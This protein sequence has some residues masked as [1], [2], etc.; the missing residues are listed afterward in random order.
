MGRHATVRL[1]DE[2]GNPGCGW[3]LLQILYYHHWRGVRRILPRRKRGK[4]KSSTWTGTPEHPQQTGNGQEFSDA[5][6]KSILI[7][8]SNPKTESG[9]KWSIK[10]RIKAL[11]AAEVSK[12]DDAK[13]RDQ[14]FPKQS[15]QKSLHANPSLH[16]L[17]KQSAGCR[18][19]N[20]LLK[21]G[22]E[23]T[24][25]S[26][27]EHHLV[28]DHET[29]VASDEEPSFEKSAISQED[30]ANQML[31]K[32][33]QLKRCLTQKDFKENLDVLEFLRVKKELSVK[34][35][36]D[37]HAAFASQLPS[38]NEA[39]QTARLIKSGS[40]PS[41][42]S[43]RIRLGTPSTLEQK[44]KE[45]WPSK[46]GKFLLTPEDDGGSHLKA[47]DISTSNDSKSG[48]LYRVRRSSSL[49]E[50][51]DKHTRLFN[52]DFNKE[53]TR[54]ISR[55][56]KLR[57]EKDFTLVEYTPNVFRR[58]LSLPEL[59]SYSFLPIDGSRDA[60]FSE[61][62]INH[63]EDSPKRMNGASDDEAASLPFHVK[64]EEP[65]LLDSMHDSTNLKDAV[66]LSDDSPVAQGS[67]TL[68]MDKDD[69]NFGSMDRHFRVMDELPVQQCCQE[70]QSMDVAA[71]GTCE[72]HETPVSNAKI[73]S[74]AGQVHSTLS[75]IPEDIELNLHGDSS[76]D[77]KSRSISTYLLDNGN[78]LNILDDLGDRIREDMKHDADLHY[79]KYVLE[80][81]ELTRRDQLQTWQLLEQPLDPALF[82]ETEAGCSVEAQCSSKA[83]AI[84]RFEH[85]VL[86]D[87]IDEALLDIFKRSCAY[88]PKALSFSCQLRPLPTGYR[89]LKEVWLLVSRYL[90]RLP[91]LHPSL[92]SAVAYD[93]SKCDGWMNLQMETECVAVELED[94]ILDE[95]LEEIISEEYFDW[96]ELLQKGYYNEVSLMRV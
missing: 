89:V 68:T 52:H 38:R 2:D 18:D 20:I 17:Q 14:G 27:Q 78:E 74:D 58:R 43:S 1:E 3:G 22:M 65:I 9:S 10:A 61:M 33:G 84:S 5:E 70:G 92:D 25:A 7:K 81:L 91:V 26:V 62:A 95:L 80:L 39:L 57:N 36:N 34:I 31:V 23:Q 15:L 75:P 66:T 72:A 88:Y 44:H 60:F 90:R 85:K 82:E 87:L 69:D 28:K 50:S 77:S 64:S 4:T 76:A 30:V 56:L 11:I 67:T 96:L 29:A 37:S 35:L 46:G 71:T 79:V 19:V 86:F 53:M 63:V 48:K 6:V 40:F 55:S 83:V 12:E 59:D 13:C 47:H 54:H 73:S 51:M 45:V 49:T 42:N 24:T 93:L 32:C 94:M 8:G 21:N 16:D 41:V